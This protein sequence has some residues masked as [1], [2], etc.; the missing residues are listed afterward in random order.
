MQGDEDNNNVRANWNE[1]GLWQWLR[2][3]KCDP[4]ASN[5]IKTGDRVA[6]RAHNDKYVAVGTE[7][8]DSFGLIANWFDP[9]Y[10]VGSATNF[11][12]ENEDSTRNRTIESG[13]VIFLKSDAAVETGANGNY[14]EFNDGIRGRTQSNTRSEGTQLVVEFARE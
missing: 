3:E 14:I 8:D 13:D 11:I 10:S 12:I 7:E 4:D 1:H 5:I 6:L 2:I 9:G